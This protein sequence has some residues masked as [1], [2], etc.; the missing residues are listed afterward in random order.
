[1]NFNKIAFLSFFHSIEKKIILSLL[2]VTCLFSCSKNEVYVPKPK[3]FHRIE[4]PI[5]EYTKLES[6]YPYS[7]DYSKHAII[8]KDSGFNTEPYW[9]EIK[10]PKLSA[11]ISVSYKDVMNSKDSLEGFVNTAFKLADKHLSRAS[12]KNEYVVK[13]PSGYGAIA[14]ELEGDVASQFQFFVTD[15]TKN[16]LRAALY[17]NTSSKNDSLAPIIEY[18]KIDMM[19]MLNS[20]EWKT[21]K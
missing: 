17:F 21:V 2:L 13:L 3:G 6:N 20:L 1:M 7:F 5:P 14:I 12:A 8:L 15:S 19:Q 11:E 4:L 9:I 18:I 16:F 10:Y